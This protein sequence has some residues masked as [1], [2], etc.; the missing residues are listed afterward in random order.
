[1]SACICIRS[2]GTI[3][4]VVGSGTL[5]G[6]RLSPVVLR[7]IIVV[8]GVAALVKFLLGEPAGRLRDACRA[9]AERR[10]GACRAPAGRRPAEDGGG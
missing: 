5:I 6:R 9:A 8:V 4:A 2:A 10:P 1:V 3:N 7:G